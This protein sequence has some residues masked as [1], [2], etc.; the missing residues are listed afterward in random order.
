MD[1]KLE[2][3]T[4]IANVSVLDRILDQNNIAKA[5]QRKQYTSAKIELNGELINLQKLSFEGSEFVNGRPYE[6]FII[7]DFGFYF[8]FDSDF[9][10]YSTNN[11]NGDINWRMHEFYLT[12]LS[13]IQNFNIQ[14]NPIFDDGRVTVSDEIKSLILKVASEK[15]Y[16]SE[17]L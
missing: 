5:P 14:D 4:E 11:G 9:Q 17:E 13:F 16:K 7:N 10:D 15:Y 1:V 2:K 6:L 3:I 12:D 8:D